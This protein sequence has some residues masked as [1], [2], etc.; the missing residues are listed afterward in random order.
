VNESL[1]ILR[2][3]G[4]LANLAWMDQ[5]SCCWARKHLGKKVTMSSICNLMIIFHCPLVRI[6][7]LNETTTNV[8]VNT[9]R[10]VHI[11]Y[12]SILF[13]ILQ[14]SN[15]CINTDNIMLP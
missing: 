15:T 2:A 13:K 6:V 8:Y 7:I 12:D 14:Y 5:N 9:L 3:H 4:L 11:E 1:R 10:T